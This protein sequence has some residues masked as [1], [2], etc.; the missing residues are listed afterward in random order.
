MNG[1][2]LGPGG[3]KQDPGLI[4]KTPEQLLRL[5]PQPLAL[6]LSEYQQEAHCYVKLHRLCECVEM[7]VRFL[8]SV[9]FGELRRVGPGSF[10]SATL[11]R[12]LL[13]DEGVRSRIARPTFG[14]WLEIL[15]AAVA[16]LS[17]RQNLVV[18]ELPG[19]AGKLA[20][21]ISPNR[22]ATPE[23]GVL[24]LRNALAHDGRFSNE[25]AER[26]LRHCGHGDRF[27]EFWRREAVPFFHPLHLFGV[28]KDG[29]AVRLRGL[30]E[31]AEDAERV[32]LVDVCDTAEPVPPA[33]SVLVTRTGSR[34]YLQLRPLVFFDRAHHSVGT[35]LEQLTQSEVS[36]VYTR[37]AQPN[38]YAVLYPGLD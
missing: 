19:F 29:E 30:V 25:R 8:V 24:K 20:G 10:P 36:Q 23:D 32:S 12:A 9:A 16:E 38:E 3:E 35:G 5:L 26:L 28:V 18:P 11:R 4:A 14:D 34:D 33:S 6:L 13:P 17:S 1:S 2:K 15:K 37:R 7:L 22:R 21:Y 27:D 31:S